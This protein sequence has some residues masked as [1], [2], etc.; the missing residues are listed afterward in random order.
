MLHYAARREP[1]RER[2]HPAGSFGQNAGLR[3]ALRIVSRESTAKPRP[4]SFALR[5]PAFVAFAR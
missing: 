1:N 5:N 4:Q 2:A 3:R